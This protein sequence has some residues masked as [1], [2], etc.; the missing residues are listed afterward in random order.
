[1]IGIYK[2]TNKMNGK[3]Y[4]GQ[5]NNIDRR[6]L[7][8]CQKGESSRIPLDAAIKKYGR[9]NF[10]L[11]I[12]EECSLDKLNSR[13]SYWIKHYDTVRKGYN[14]NPGGDNGQVGSSNSN[15]KLTEEDVIL[16]RKA[17]NE[18]KTQ[19]DVYDK[20]FKNKITFN[21]FQNIWQGR[22]W[23]HIMP[24]VFTEKNKKYFIHQNSV[25]SRSVKAELS[26]REVLE[27]R[28]RYIS[29]TAKQIYE[30]YKDRLKLQTLQA[31]L[32]GRTYTNLPIYSKK[33]KTWINK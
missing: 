20:H 26:D 15:S 17:Y 32:W 21:H 22:V 16:I 11:E 14:C 5:A 23:P 27:I 12:L 19:K 24:E 18:H 1:M 4:I 25:G 3:T 10:T 9:A 8:H 6:F 30:D 31:I 7:E 2:I 13:E 29:E 28:T 33:Q